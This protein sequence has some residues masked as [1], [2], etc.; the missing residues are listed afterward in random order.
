ML[1]KRKEL[2]DNMKITVFTGNQ[3][4]H[5]A[6]V[7][8]L[9]EI[10]DE[11]Y[12]VQECKT[13]F[14]GKVDDIAQK[15]EVMKLYFDYVT[16]AEKKVFGKY[17]F[18]KDNIKT[19]A[20]KNG[21][22]RYLSL[23]DIPEIEGSDYYI[24]F[25]SSYIKGS[26]LEYLIAHKAI[27]IHIGVSPYYRGSACN[28]WAMYDHKPEYV[29]ATVHLLDE[30]LDGGEILFHALPKAERYNAYEIGMRAVEAVIRA[31]QQKLKEHWDV[32]S[33]VKPESKLEIRL[34]KRKEFTDEVA[35]R[36]ME[37][38][39][40]PDEIYRSLL[41]RDMHQYIKPWIME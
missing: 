31:L 36:Y 33:V 12:A 40:E 19:F 13:I 6:F 17:S 15:S 32:T 30:R 28:F 38:L 2:L 1:R 8:A 9:S 14:P 29:G 41:N 5:I 10:A 39:P 26:L 27:N 3:L 16:N 24:V 11:V 20:I 34:A 37:N 21:D 22:L 23:E 25:G 18:F 4:R 35:A 7:N